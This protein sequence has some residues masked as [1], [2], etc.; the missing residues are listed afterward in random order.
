MEKTNLKDLQDQNGL[1]DSLINDSPSWPASNEFPIIAFEPMPANYS[2]HYYP[3]DKVTIKALLR[4]VA[5]CGIDTVNVLGGMYA[6]TAHLKTAQELET[7]GNNIKIKVIVNSD[8]LFEN[9]KSCLEMVTAL[10]NYDNLA[11]WNVKDEPSP[12]DWGEVLDKDGHVINPSGGQDVKYQIYNRDTIWHRLTIGYNLVRSLDPSRPVYFN[13]AVGSSPNITGKYYYLYNSVYEKNAEYLRH[14]N[15]LYHPKVWS[16]DYYPV[17]CKLK[18][19]VPK[20]DKEKEGLMPTDTQ[21]DTVVWYNELF[22]Y[23]QCFQDIT[24]A[25]GSKFL[26]FAN[27]MHYNLYNSDGTFNVKYPVPTIGKLRLEVFSAMC[28]GASGI[29]YYRYG[30]GPDTIANQ[31]EPIDWQQAF[32]SFES[33]VSYKNQTIVKSPTIWPLVKSMNEQIRLW[34]NLFIG[35]TVGKHRHAYVPNN[36]EGDPVVDVAVDKLSDGDLSNTCIQTLKC[37]F[38]KNATYI[39]KENASYDGKPGNYVTT[40]HNQPGILL[41]WFTNPSYKDDQYKNG[42][43]HYIA[44]LNLDIERPQQL[45]LRLNKGGYYFLK[46]TKTGNVSTCSLSSTISSP[47]TDNVITLSPGE[48]IVLFW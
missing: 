45:T 35:C 2:Q 31:K 27:C 47:N 39:D 32:V 13:L 29:V 11:A 4:A 40:T 38:N 42:H 46:E 5:D 25:T 12:N 33:A 37:H 9:P 36:L 7:L 15:R 43:E 14:L 18:N 21:L 10:Q 16:F 8:N 22:T 17:G 20:K 23:L 41:S 3:N 28:F 44:L 34:Q 1:Q 19:N 48:M 30:L 26:A 24:Q 6:Q